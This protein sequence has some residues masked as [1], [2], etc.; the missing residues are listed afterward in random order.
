[1]KMHLTARAPSEGARHL[2]RWVARECGG[3]LEHA[4]ALISRRGRNTMLGVS[5]MALQ[6]MIDGEIV[7]GMSLGT[8]LHDI[9][10]IRARMFNRPADGGWFDAEQ[11]AAA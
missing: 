5:G 11:K 8:V 9:F 3:D 7:P 6:R 1:M 2:A 10:G 4:A